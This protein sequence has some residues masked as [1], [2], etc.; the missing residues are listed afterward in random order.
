MSQPHAVQEALRFAMELCLPELLTRRWRVLRFDVPL[1]T[2]DAPVTPWSP[3]A[4]G[5]ERASPP[6]IATARMIVLALDRYTALAMVHADSDKV[7]AAPARRALQINTAV[8]NNAHRWIFHHPHD[9]PL[10]DVRI[11]P[12]A[13]VTDEIRGARA[14]DDGSVGILHWLVK[15]PAP[16]TQPH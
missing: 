5:D 6:G 7:V 4:P 12:P 11:D 10:V 15:R 13:V 2:S 9:A 1:V 16:R 8:A 3:S 14:H